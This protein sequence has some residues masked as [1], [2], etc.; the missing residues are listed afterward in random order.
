M[1]VLFMTYLILANTCLIDGFI[2]FIQEKKKG[3]W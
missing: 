3:G 2:I 1:F